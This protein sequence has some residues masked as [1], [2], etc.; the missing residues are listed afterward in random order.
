MLNRFLTG[1]LLLAIFANAVFALSLTHMQ[2]RITLTLG[3]A[4]SDSI[5]VASI[6]AIEA[7]MLVSKAVKKH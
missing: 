3:N 2:A 6:P 7:E 5:Q 4:P 1:M